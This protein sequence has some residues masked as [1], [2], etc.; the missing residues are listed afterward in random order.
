MN[1]W[2]RELAKYRTKVFEIEAVQ[3][4]GDN[5]AEVHAFTEGPEGRSQFAWISLGEGDDVRLADETDEFQAQ[6]YDT[7][8]DSWVNV[9]IGQ[10]IIRGMKGEYYP[11]DPE[12]FDA[13]YELVNEPIT[14]RRGHPSSADSIRRGAEVVIESGGIVTSKTT[15]PN[16]TQ[17]GRFGHV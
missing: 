7:L 16:P 13:K 1:G 8:H 9:K 14:R 4:T 12:V 17:S 15:K 5:F 2:D 6:V 10:W 11:C 3:F